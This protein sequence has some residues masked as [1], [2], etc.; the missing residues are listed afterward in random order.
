MSTTPLTDAINALTRY[1]NETTGASDTT[2]SDAVGTLV[3][4]YGGGGGSE[5]LFYSNGA[6]TWNGTRWNSIPLPNT[7]PSGGCVEAEMMIVA[8]TNNPNILSVGKNYNSLTAWNTN[9]ACHIM[10]N[11]DSKIYIRQSSAT[12]ELTSVTDFTVPHT[13]K[14]DKDYIYVD[15]VPILATASNIVNSSV[16]YIGGNDFTG[17]FNY[18]RYK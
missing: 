5:W 1:A 16:I 10:L 8:A 9:E 2:L 4:G 12:T 3:A 13:F 17:T 11:P 14:V 15:G 18:I 7:L 6:S